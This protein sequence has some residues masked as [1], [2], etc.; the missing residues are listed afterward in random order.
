MTRKWIS[1]SWFLYHDNAP[2]HRSVL[3]KDFLAKNNVATLENPPHFPDLVAADF[4]L[5]PLLKSVLNLRCFCVATDIFQNATEEL[6]RL[7]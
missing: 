1:N 5:L 6:K 7:S 3:I 4:H 2:A